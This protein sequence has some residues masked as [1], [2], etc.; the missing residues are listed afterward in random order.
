M[1]NKPPGRS[2][3]TAIQ[4]TS[5]ASDATRIKARALRA[6]RAATRNPDPS[7]LMPRREAVSRP[8][9][10]ALSPS[11]FP[12]LRLFSQ[13]IPV[14]PE[15]ALIFGCFHPPGW[16]RSAVLQKGR[17]RCSSANAGQLRCRWGRRRPGDGPFGRGTV[18]TSAPCVPWWKG[19]KNAG[20]LPRID[21]G[22]HREKRD[23]PAWAC[24]F[25]FSR[26]RSVQGA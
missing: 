3:L 20:K 9:L 21:T 11:A 13:T 14:G 19:K 2:T 5:S 8:P 23:R 1:G 7:P 26:N 4:G 16:G 22:G 25:S 6:A 24:P 12:P 17:T 10:R 15:N 18:N